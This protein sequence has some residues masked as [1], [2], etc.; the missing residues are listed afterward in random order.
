MY[1]DFGTGQVL[2]SFLWFFLFLIFVALLIVVVNDIFRSPDLSGWAKALWTL[3]VIVVPFIGIAIY[4]IVH[5]GK[6]RQLSLYDRP[7]D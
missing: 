7:R 3:L 5:G 1:A 6:M 2:W 4:L